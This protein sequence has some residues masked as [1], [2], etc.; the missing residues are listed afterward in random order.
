MSKGKT[1]GRREFFGKSF[2]CAAGAGLVVDTLPAN[3]QTEQ[4]NKTLKIRRYRTLG[5]TGFKV[6]DIGFGASFLTNPNVLQV[7]MDMGVN[8]IDTGE[9]YGG[10]RSETS[11]GEAI[12]SRD[13]NSIFITTKLNLNWGG[14]ADKKNILNRFHK[15]LD[16]LQTDYADCLMIHMCNDPEQVK[17]VDFHAA[18]KQLQ[19]E[20]KIK[21]IGLSNHGPEQR[22]YG[23]MEVP[24][25]KVMLTAAEDGRFDVGLFVY[26]FLQ[27]EQGEKI[28]EACKKKDMGITLMKTNPVK[29]YKRWKTGLKR[30]KE[31]GE[32][33]PERKLKLSEEYQNWLKNSEIFKKKHGLKSDEDVR[34]AAIAFVLS[35]PDTHTICFSINSFAELNTFMNL[36]G[37]KLSMSNNK[38][39]DD[40]E[41]SLGSFYC[42]H[43]CGSCESIC[44]ENVPINTVL[45][46][47]HYFEAQGQEKHA[48]QKYNDLN[49][50]AANCST[51]SG[52][53]ETVCPYQ[54]R[55]RSLLVDANDNLTLT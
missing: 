19:A 34:D 42:R 41:K 48:I 27:K 39:L 2:I 50:K 32:E 55:V 24:M 4:D 31:R 37:R 21:F 23:H 8:Y 11:I 14:S 16:R 54:V 51:C 12:K 38:M 20:G 29:V 5:R 33:I 15:C 13:R 35:N 44:P 52:A 36:S 7:A 30:Y 40:Y 45:R 9:H 22:I 28:I 53:C 3:S 1:I 26:N 43:A 6:A 47:N 25:E 10:G 46:Y 18:A 49:Q 17:H